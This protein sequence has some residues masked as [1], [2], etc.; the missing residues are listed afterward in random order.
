MGAPRT[1]MSSFLTNCE[2]TEETE[3]NSVSIDNMVVVNTLHL[4]Y[5]IDE[6]C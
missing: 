5:V 1:N 3:T 6:K 2:E 4:I